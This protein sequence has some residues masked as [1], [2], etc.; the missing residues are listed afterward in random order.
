MNTSS[1]TPFPFSKLPSYSADALSLMRRLETLRA[2]FSGNKAVLDEILD[3]TEAVLKIPLEA[4]IA[5]VDALSLEEAAAILPENALLVLIRME[6]QPK[7]AFLAFDAAFAHF[8]VNAALSG[9]RAV[10]EP[11]GLDLVRPV[12]PLCEGVLQYAVVSALEKIAPMLKAS[13]LSPVFD[14][15]VRDAARLK[16]LYANGDRFAVFHASVTAAERLFSVRLVLPLAVAE[17]AGNSFSPAI[18]ETLQRLPTINGDFELRIGGVGVSADDISGLMPGDIVLL[19]DANIAWK[20]GRVVSGAGSLHAAGAED[21]TGINVAWE[22]T[23][24]GIKT[25]V[26]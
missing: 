26:R 13:G 14:D 9:G 6:P 17:K 3:A 2:A 1:V 4:H 15:V 18:G 24:A 7:R 16:T 20:S 25:T 21:E 8:L 12:T 23:S 10:T 5:G 11:S 19:D 22:M